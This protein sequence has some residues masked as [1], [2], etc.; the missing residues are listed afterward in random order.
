MP[1]LLDVL[2]ETGDQLVLLLLHVLHLPGQVCDTA[3][4]FFLS[5]L[6]MNLQILHVLDALLLDVVL[7]L[8]DLGLGVLEL[9]I[10]GDFIE[11]VLVVII[12]LLEVSSALAEGG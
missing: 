6:L 4:C 11:A 7:Q 8:L 1:L 3:L 9:F 2:L 12:F 5:F 10:E